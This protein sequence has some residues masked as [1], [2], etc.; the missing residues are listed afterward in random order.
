MTPVISDAQRAEA[1]T[2]LKAIL[3]GRV[4]AV[5]ILDPDRPDDMEVATNIPPELCS[6]LI[7]MAADYE[8]QEVVEVRQS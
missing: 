2:T 1:V 7:Q 8:T 5:L 6:K 4:F 3:P